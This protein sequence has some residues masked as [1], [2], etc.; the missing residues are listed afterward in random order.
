MRSLS[1]TKLV[2]LSKHATKTIGEMFEPQGVCAKGC[3][4]QMV[5]VSLWMEA[6]QVSHRD[7]LMASSPVTDT[8][9]AYAVQM[10]LWLMFKLLPFQQ[11]PNGS[12]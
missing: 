6:C 5:L 4:M 8:H 9:E 7:C 3:M 11:R 2:L 1:N 10:S 12:N